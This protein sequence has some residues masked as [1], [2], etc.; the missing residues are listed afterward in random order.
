MQ[1]NSG[2]KKIMLALIFASPCLTI[3]MGDNGIV[4]AAQSNVGDVVPARQLNLRVP[5]G[6][7]LAGTKGWIPVAPFSG[8]MV[9]V[10]VTDAPIPPHLRVTTELL[11]GSPARAMLSQI[12]MVKKSLNGQSKPVLPGRHL[13][14]D[15]E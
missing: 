9:C 14:V 12:I 6:P 11:P 1:M 5:V 13:Q 2:L 10:E 15:E 4:R 3:A 7:L 8:Y